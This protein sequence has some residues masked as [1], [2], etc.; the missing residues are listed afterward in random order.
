[1]QPFF[2]IIIPVYNVAPYLRKCLDSISAQTFTDWEAICID[3]GSTDGS[4]VILDQYAKADKRFR[5]IHQPNSG[6]CAARQCGLKMATG[7]WIS[8]VDPDDWVDQSFLDDF[9]VAVQGANIDM[10][11]SDYYINCGEVETRCRQQC[12]EESRCILSKLISGSLMGSMCNKVF[13]RK[14]IEQYSIAFP[15]PKVI[16]WEDLWF[17][18]SFI[19]HNPGV[20]YTKK[21]GYHYFGRDGSACRRWLTMGQLQSEIMVEQFLE[22]LD[23]PHESLP[24]LE[25][26]RSDIK[27]SAYL[28]PNIDD[29]AFYACYPNIRELSPSKWR[30]WHRVLFWLAMRGF[31][32]STSLVFRGIIRVRHWIDD[33]CF[34]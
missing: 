12:N 21:C 2:S 29:A 16:M 25:M 13:S 31:R 9:Y 26:R 17:V 5:V 22:S 11:W 7:A 14:F 27:F 10:A 28:S 3:D 24:N 6:V 34:G 19:S 15:D 23:L 4:S 8:A 18:A 33:G 20:K 30:L 1:M 32:R